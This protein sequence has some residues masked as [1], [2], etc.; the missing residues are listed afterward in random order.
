MQPVQ[1][2]NF[3]ERCGA[4]LAS[5]VPDGDSRERRVCPLCHHVHYLQPKVA[6]GTIA[7]IGGKI[8][9]IKRNVEP[10]KGFWSFPCGFVEMDETLEEAARRETRE[11]AGV[12]VEIVGHLGTYSYPSAYG[13]HVVV[14]AYHAMVTGGTPVAG[15]DA[16]D[17]KLIER[18]TVPWDDLAFLSSHEAIKA[19]LA[20]PR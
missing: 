6:A 15:D 18:N 9:L 7:E 16:I 4:K 2:P 19:W 17:L 10:R 3:C 13:V 11:E 12:D 8:V 14:V 20:K 1:P 5:K